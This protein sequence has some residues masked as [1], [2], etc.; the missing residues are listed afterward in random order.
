MRRS[1]TG[2]PPDRTCKVAGIPLGGAVNEKKD[3]KAVANSHTGAPPDSTC[4]PCN[5]RLRS[6]TCNKWPIVTPAPGRVAMV[7]GTGKRNKALRITA[8]SLPKVTSM[9]DQYTQMTTAAYLYLESKTM[10]RGSEVMTDALKTMPGPSS[11]WTLAA[12]V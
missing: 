11:Q 7:I 10:L 9:R 8:D 5:G 1:H 2:A 12:A 6:G 3:C 4:K